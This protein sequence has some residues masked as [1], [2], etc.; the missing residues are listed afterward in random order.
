MVKPRLEWP[1]RDLDHALINP[2]NKNQVKDRGK[3]NVT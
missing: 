3:I 2:L 1:E